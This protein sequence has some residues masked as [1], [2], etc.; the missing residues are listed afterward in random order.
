MVIAATWFG[1]GLAKK[2]PGTFGTLATV[3]LILITGQANIFV[4]LAVLLIVT[5]VG[6][7]AAGYYETYTGKKDPGAVVIDETAGYYLTMIFFP[8]TLWTV[9]AGFVFF[10]LFDIWKPYPIKRYEAIG[11]GIGIMVDDLV[12]GLYAALAMNI[13]F[14]IFPT[15][16]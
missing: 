3:P 16:L 1:S 14:R 4:K 12:A 5:V 11:G 13:F 8:V 9:V 7:Y 15:L 10:R 6:I 2:A